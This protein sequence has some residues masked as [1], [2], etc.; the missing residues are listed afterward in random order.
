MQ[1]NDFREAEGLPPFTESTCAEAAALTRAAALIGAAELSHAPMKPVLDSC[2]VN[3]SA[4]NLANSSASPREVVAAWIE[5]PGHRN[6]MVDASL[7]KLGVGCVQNGDD[8][9]CAQI[10]LG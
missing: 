9:L 4:E 1:T 8:M 6:N 3:L 10:F 2:D 5:S 7:Q